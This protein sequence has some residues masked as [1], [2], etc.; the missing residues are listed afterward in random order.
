MITGMADDAIQHLKQLNAAAPDKPFFLYYVP[1]GSHAPHQPTPEMDRKVQGQ[2]R[3]GLELKIA[4]SARD[5]C[6]VTR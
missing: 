5:P 3:H 2:V 4:C 6:P 1:G